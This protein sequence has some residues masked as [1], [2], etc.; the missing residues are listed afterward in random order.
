MGN[1]MFQYALGRHL[2]LIHKWPL[3]LDLSYYTE[4]AGDPKKGIRIY[5]LD[6]FNI[7][8][9]IASA[10]DT[11]SFQIFL[12]KNILSKILRHLSG[13]GEYYKRSFIFEPPKNYFKF[14]PHLLTEP[15]KSEV[16]LDGFWQTEK[17][18]SAIENII[19]QDFTF[20]DAPGAVNQAMLAHIDIA[21][22]VCLHIR[23]GDN[24]TKIAAKH[25]VLP[26]GYYQQA[27]S[28]LTKTISSPH[29]YI[30]SDDP[31]WAR[32]NLRLEYPATFVSHNGDEKNYEDL[33]LM[34]RCKHHIIGNSTFSWW[35]A[36]LGKKPGQIVYAPKRY[37]VNDN[38]PTVD[39]YPKVWK[40]INN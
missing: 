10:E 1:Q 12:K 14:D 7:Q 4:A 18:F 36:W 21:E 31:E 38:I 17:Y 16:Y 26:F 5:G 30:F 33:R 20:K 9:G 19:R 15:L 11:L 40:L 6:H 24:A 28:E 39:L 32:E 2:S 3:K 8:A 23:H 13:L 34:T 22:S 25:G 29:F 27:I 37:H 35:G